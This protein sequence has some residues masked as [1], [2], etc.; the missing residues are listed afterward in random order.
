MEKTSGSGITITLAD[1]SVQTLEEVVDEDAL[2][3][4]AIQTKGEGR[5]KLYHR[6]HL[7]LAKAGDKRRVTKIY[8]AREVAKLNWERRKMKVTGENVTTAICELLATG[9]TFS[10]KDMFIAFE[11]KGGITLTL[12]Q[13][14]TRFNFMIY[15]TRMKHILQDQS[16]GATHFYT[17]MTIAQDLSAAELVTVVYSKSRPIEYKELLEKYPAL[18]LH[19]QVMESPDV[20]EEEVETKVEEVVKNPK[21]ESP[22]PKTLKTG[23]EEKMGEVLSEAFGVKV[24]V[25][26][27]VEIV[28]KFG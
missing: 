20:S 6:P 24:E 27:K 3:E 14:R 10:T 13:L 21:T 18:G 9:N 2:R 1:G 8:T 17:V 12:Q 25:T 28:F 23:I 15:Q 7:R 26:G 19:M 11:D 16:S 4:V 22:K 5:Y